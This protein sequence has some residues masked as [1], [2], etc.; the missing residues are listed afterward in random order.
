VPDRVEKVGGGSCR[1]VS[2]LGFGKAGLEIRLKHPSFPP[3]A[4]GRSFQG[5]VTEAETLFLQAAHDSRTRQ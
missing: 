2:G 5:K 3:P 1:S 4:E